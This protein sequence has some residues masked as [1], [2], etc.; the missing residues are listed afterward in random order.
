MSPSLLISQDL[1]LEEKSESAYF[2]ALAKGMLREK[3]I[4]YHEVWR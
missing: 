4:D 3:A 2:L 1:G